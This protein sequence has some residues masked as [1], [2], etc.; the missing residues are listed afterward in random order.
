MAPAPREDVDDLL[1]V[2]ARRFG[3]PSRDLVAAVRALTDVQQID[4]LILVAANAP[5]LD[6]FRQ[7][8]AYGSRAF[9]V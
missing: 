3:P 6:V 4:R 8:M 2:L 9:R 7:E 5:D 1:E